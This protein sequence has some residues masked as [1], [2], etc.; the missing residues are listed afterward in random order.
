MENW[1]MYA[2]EAAVWFVVAY[3][4]AVSLLYVGLFLTA[5]PKI[6][7]ERKLN[8][9]EQIE[10]LS[11][12]KD[13][14]PLSIL[15]PAY[16]EEV[17]ITT[18]IRSL[19]SVHYPEYEVIVINDGSKDA[20][21]EKVIHEFAMT[22]VTYSVRK[23]MTTEAV[24]AVYQSELFPQLFLLEKENGGKADA[25]NAGINFSRY[26]YFA[27]IDAD[28]VLEEDALLK[29]MKPIIDSNGKVTVT[30]G[31]VRIANGCEIDG[32]VIKRISLPKKPLE[33]MQIIEYFRGFLIG[34]L[35]FS[36]ANMLLIVS[37]A[38]GVFEKSR[39]IQV[40]GYDT[41]TVG[42][43]MELIVRIHRSLRDEQSS[44]RIEYIQDP[45]CWTEAPSSAKVL[46]AQRVRW[47]RGLAET[48]FKHKKMIFNPAYGRLGMI[49]MP[50]YLF[51]ELLSAVFELL[52]YVIILFGIFYFAE[53]NTELIVM[54]FFATVLYGSLLSSFAVLLEEWT[55][56]KYE[57]IKSLYVLYLCALTESFWYRPLTVFYRI[58]GLIAF[59]KKSPAWGDMQRRGLAGKELKR[60]E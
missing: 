30:G 41:G 29:T 55:Y 4:I 39:V 53:T 27:A 42:E 58:N 50:Y 38:F 17:G 2:A 9:K 22:K 57:D 20:T 26:P 18:S 36:R 59:F 23:H 12:H 10:E 11:F 5:V 14:Y 32:S 43:D 7:R 48:L 21:A 49:S 28:S 51:V 6:R 52:G 13:T 3:M 1:L 34:R 16:N 35:G 40:G 60:E 31:T 33:I 24:T 37:G 45:V 54:I 25:L 46:R 19:L 15:V 56:H 44:Q 47:Q 8:R